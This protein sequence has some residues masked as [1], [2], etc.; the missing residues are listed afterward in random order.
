MKRFA[1]LLVLFILLALSTVAE[2]PAYTDK[3]NDAFMRD[4]LLCGPFPC[5]LPGPEQ[6]APLLTPAFENDLLTPIGGETN[7]R[8]EEGVAM[9]YAGGS[10]TW[11]RYTSPDDVVSL[12][13]AISN[14]SNVF[15]YAYCEIKSS[16]AQ[17]AVLLV[18]ANDGVRAWFNGERVIS[19]PEPSGLRKDEFR[20]PV[21]MKAGT[22]TLLMKVE[23]RGALWQLC[24]R[25]LPFDKDVF[26]KGMPLFRV[27]TSND[28]QPALQYLGTPGL[29]KHLFTQ[30]HLAARPKGAKQP[31]WESNLDGSAELPLGVPADRYGEYDLDA[32]IT[33]RNGETVAMTIPFFAGKR[34]QH[35]LFA[36]GASDYKIVLTPNAS[37][38]E[39]WA[40]VELADRLH[41]ISGVTLP[42]VTTD[43][44][45]PNSIVLGH[46]AATGVDA[47]APG[48]ESFTYLNQGPTIHI[49]GGSERGTMYGVLTFLERELGVRWY[50]KH[51]TVT[52]E[53]DAY[54]FNY[55]RHGEAPGLRVRNDFYHEAFD[56]IWAARQK[57]NGAMSYREQ[58]GGVEAYWSVHTFYP[59]MPPDEFFADHPEY[60]SLIDGKREWDHAQLC[61]TNP[62]VLR[63]MTERVKQRMRDMPEYR[64]Y[65]VSQNDWRN[66]CQCA[67]CQAIVEREG[68]E[69]GPLIEFV[70]AIADAVKD[71]F[72]DKYIGTLAYQYTRK[73]PRTISPR[74]NVVVRLCS[75]EC[76]FA[77][78]FKS[79]PEN[80]EFLADLQAW[81]G[82]APHMYI[83]DYVVDF[84]HYIL[85]FPNF[86]VL[87]SN[88][89][90]F[91]DNNAI[92]IM[93]QAA[94]QSR[95]G[96]FAELRAYV[97]A[98]L[99]WNPDCDVNEV[100]NDFMYGYYGRAGQYVRQYLNLLHG[101]ITPDTHMTIWMGP[102][103]VLFTDGFVVKA[104]ALFDEAERVA[105]SEAIRQRVEM[106]RLPVM[107]LKCLRQPNTAKQD[108]TYARFTEIVERE[109]ITHYAESGA[110]HKAA[111][112]E[113]MDAIE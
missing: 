33:M 80:Q 17:P 79:C 16:S 18:G 111:F 93:E 71:E 13:D 53:R 37:D 100:I 47:P 28:G 44:P 89:K 29:I 66:P 4:W 85:P 83:W 5:P 90:S 45:E 86:K 36:N 68:T 56:P 6:E 81:A 30:V 98:K 104:E 110:P 11:T 2:M 63:I 92:G 113:K 55:L 96:E 95:G 24:A 102:D 52:P 61:L 41:D 108:G 78:D 22:N 73:P 69:A 94:Y 3:P 46:T 65:S 88:I 60:Y 107:Y 15:A 67:K 87:Q 14:A 40:A 76:C 77:H 32:T 82:I 39:K 62:D 64:I 7:P 23:E 99:L 105:D 57:V 50:S 31:V 74:E 8:V 70:N 97:I 27:N 103:H 48:D 35:A 54:Q 1:C 58:P 106:A 43:S 9:P 34:E 25:L 72:P 59:I 21:A 19:E 51:V 49:W 91:R 26:H 109:G 75:I 12:D 84:H 38:S 101:Q 42:V 20:T 10:A 112:H